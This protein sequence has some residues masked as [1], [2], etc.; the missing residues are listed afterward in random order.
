MYKERPSVVI[1]NDMGNQH[2]PTTIIAP[3][4]G[5]RSHYPFYANLSAT[6]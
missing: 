6:T 1:Q 3:I 2:S 4:T 5:G